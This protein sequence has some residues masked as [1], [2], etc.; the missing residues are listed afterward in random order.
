MLLPHL[1]IPTL[2]VSLILFKRNNARVRDRIILMD[3]KFMMIKTKLTLVA[4]FLE[5]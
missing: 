1:P 2:L 4:Y 5:S 3:V